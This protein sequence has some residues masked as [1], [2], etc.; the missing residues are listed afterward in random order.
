MINF[1]HILVPIDFSEHSDRALEYGK[2]L[3]EKFGADL[4]LLHVLEV[5]LSAPNFGMGAAV[6]NRIEE[7]ADGV[8]HELNKLAADWTGTVV[9]ATAHGSPIVAINDYAKENEIDLIALGTQGRTGLSHLLLGS[10]A[11]NVS[12]HAPCPVMIVR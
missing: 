12:R 7:S 8:M 9:R 6:P 11:E 2:E 10:V 1:K 3:C 5:R 4:H